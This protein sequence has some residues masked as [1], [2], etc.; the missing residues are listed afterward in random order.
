MAAKTS[1]WLLRTSSLSHPTLTT[2]A[3][4]A[5]LWAYRLLGASATNG[6]E[7]IGGEIMECLRESCLDFLCFLRD[8]AYSV[9]NRRAISVGAE[10]KHH[11]ALAEEALEVIEAAPAEHL[12]SVLKPLRPALIPR[13]GHC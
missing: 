12:P 1:I 3:R 8:A 5:G 9:T 13:V 2:T 7:M 6:F 10:G 11:F 4:H